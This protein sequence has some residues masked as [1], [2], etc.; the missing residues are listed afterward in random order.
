MY[1][2]VLNF[3]TF[4]CT[5]FPL[6]PVMLAVFLPLHYMREVWLAITAGSTKS[7]V[8][9]C[10]TC[11]FF[12]SKLSNLH[13]RFDDVVIIAANLEYY[14]FFVNKLPQLDVLISFVASVS[15]CLIK[16]NGEYMESYI[17]FPTRACICYEIHV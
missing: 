1:F 2:F 3:L 15:Y 8:L 16:C 11:S 4:I 13:K 7:F 6:R 14:H 12:F 9:K 10:H 5:V 17:F